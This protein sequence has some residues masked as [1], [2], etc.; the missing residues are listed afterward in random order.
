M[1]DI[2]MRDRG[3]W[4]RLSRI[5]VL[6]HELPSF[7][8][9]VCMEAAG[10][11]LLVNRAAHRLRLRTNAAVLVVPSAYASRLAGDNPDCDMLDTW[12]SGA[13][14]DLRAVDFL[15][16]PMATADHWSLL[17][18]CHPGGLLRAADRGSRA[19]QLQ[20]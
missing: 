20:V 7:R 3:I 5:Q 9:G 12:L 10:V 18:L 16:I 15:L 13:G 4:E 14:R 19:V 8:P 17:V 2:S 1:D 11:M 6:E